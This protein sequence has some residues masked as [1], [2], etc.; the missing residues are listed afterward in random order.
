MTRTR[1]KN[2]GVGLGGALSHRDDDRADGDCADG[3]CADGD[4][5]DGDALDCLLPLNWLTVT[6]W[7]HHIT[8]RNQDV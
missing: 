7:G 6:Q 2:L 3:D 8:P 4:C 5:A 1:S